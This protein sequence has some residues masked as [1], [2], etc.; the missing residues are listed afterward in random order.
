[1][2]ELYLP[3]FNAALDSILKDDRIPEQAWKTI[4]KELTSRLLR[5]ASSTIKPIGT[6]NTHHYDL[7]RKHLPR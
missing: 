7:L 2:K 4:D 3:K 6:S 5:A 1:M